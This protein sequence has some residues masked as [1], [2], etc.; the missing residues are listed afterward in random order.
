VVP[1]SLGQNKVYYCT[2][3]K[4]CI[5]VCPTDALH[6]DSTSGAVTLDVELCTACNKCV[7]ICPTHVIIKSDQGILAGGQELPWYPV[8]CDLCDGAPACARICPTGA[9]TMDER[10]VVK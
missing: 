8:I 5:E 3:C 9:I 1:L 7:E 2:L 4:K 10:K 6:W